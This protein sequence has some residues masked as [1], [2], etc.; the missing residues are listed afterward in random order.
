MRKKRVAIAVGGTGGHVIPAQEIGGDLKDSCD[1]IYV[2][3]DLGQNAFFKGVNERAFTIK[4]SPRSFGLRRVIVDNL[5]GFWQART[6]LKKEGVDLVIGMGSY[7]SFSVILAAISLGIPY[8]LVELNVIPGRTNAIFSRWAKETLVHFEPS[9]SWL[10]GKGRLVGLSD[11]ITKELNGKEV[12]RKRFGFALDIPVI[13][14]FGGSGGAKR[15][16]ELFL[17]SLEA[18]DQIQVIHVT[19]DVDKVRQAYELLK[20]R[21]F[22]APFITD[23]NAAWNA[24]DFAITRAGGGAL[25]AM[26]LH[27]KP[28]ILVPY[29]YSVRNHQEVNAKFI[30]DEVGGGQLFIQKQLTA[31]DLRKAVFAFLNKKEL[32]KMTESL[33]KYR[34][35]HNYPKVGTA[36]WESL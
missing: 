34:K 25:K 10:K 7:H 31:K 27:Q 3:V 19:K 17:D 2:G 14:V 5:K 11:R 23:I 15:L 21:A 30:C 16:D 29:P 33:V 18:L 32:E 26:I 22:V 24:C 12:D 4:G 9:L 28:A 6:I 20:I 8:K 35:Y 1:V 36:I 13:L